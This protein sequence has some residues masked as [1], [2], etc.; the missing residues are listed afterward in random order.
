MR[1]IFVITLFMAFAPFIVNAADS[2][3]FEP[4]IVILLPSQVSADGSLQTEIDEV[5][6]QILSSAPSREEVQQY[7]QVLDSETRENVRM[8]LRRKMEFLKDFGFY[9]Q[10]SSF[11]EFYLQIKLLEVFPNLVIYAAPEKSDGSKESLSRIASEHNVRY[12]LNY[13]QIRSFLKSGQKASEVTI[14]LYDAKENEIAFDESYVGGPQNQ[15]F[16]FACTDGSV[17]CTINNALAQGLPLAMT[18]VIERSPS[19]QKAQSLAKRRSDILMNEYFSQEPNA[20]IPA[21]IHSSDTSISTDD[22][23]QAVMDKS[24]NKFVAF[25]LRKEHA[26]NIFDLKKRDVTIRSNDPT[27]LEHVPPML[28]YIVLGVQLDGVWYVKEDQVNIFESSS[29]S[30]GRKQYFNG[31]QS[32]GFFIDGTVTVNPDFWETN[33]FSRVEDVTIRSDYK[34]HYESVY[35]TYD[36]NNR[37]YIGMYEIVA[38]VL[39][40]R[41]AGDRERF[42]ENLANSTLLPFYQRMKQSDSDTFA[43]YFMI[44]EEPTLIYAS[45]RELVLNPVAIIDTSGASKLRYFAVIPGEGTVYEWTYFTPKVISDPSHYYNTEL[46]SQLDEITEWNFSFNTLEDTAFWQTYVLSRDDDGYKYLKVVS[47]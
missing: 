3:Q 23:F 46:R 9:R 45:N 10:V 20:D 4:T 12:V 11:T 39:R 34:D 7:Q 29:L 13:S 31:L 35:M 37:R 2:T 47:E 25:F 8:M 1:Q 5:T 21:I 30:E 24:E 26:D 28:A 22:F 43:D 36:N 19:I 42:E 32:W 44:R 15:G 27:N 41:D 6:T 18:I 16:H 40:K 14:Q 33:F 17:Q 38:D